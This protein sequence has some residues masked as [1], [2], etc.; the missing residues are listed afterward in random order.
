MKC[1][2]IH[3]SK[4]APEGQ[5][6]CSRQCAPFAELPNREAPGTR[7]ALNKDE[8]EQFRKRARYV[9]R[10][11]G[12]PQLAEDFAQEIFVAFARGRRATLDQ[13]FIDFLRKYQGDS[14]TDRGRARQDA[15][16]R[17]VSLDEPAGPESGGMLRHELVGGAGGDPE[18]RLDHL[19][20]SHLFGGVEAQV[21][22]LHFVE[23]LPLGECALALG[24]SASRVSQLVGRMRETIRDDRRFKVLWERYLE[25][26][27]F[28]VS[29]LQSLE[30][31]WVKM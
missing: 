9:A 31:A 13:L 10:K 21:Y 18:S 24:V 27:G 3:C 26:S 5:S 25:E 22:Q 14:G 2:R 4:A 1:R 30:V 7:E 11:R 17:A 28:G 23:Q 12:H 16:A 20:A 29:D 8:I 15:R 19:G 6:Y